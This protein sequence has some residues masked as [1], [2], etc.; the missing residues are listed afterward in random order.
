MGWLPRLDVVQMRLSVLEV[1]AQKPTGTAVLMACT[2]LPLLLTV[3]L[4]LP[5]RNLLRWLPR[6]DVDQMRLSVLRDAVPKPTGTAV[7]MTHTV[8]PLLLTAHL[9][10]PR[11]SL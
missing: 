5:K 11:R 2:V 3:H 6:L 1:V 4:F 8:L 10:L 9:F 7:L